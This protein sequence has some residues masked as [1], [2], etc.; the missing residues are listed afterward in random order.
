MSKLITGLFQEVF[1]RP[2]SPSDTDDKIMIQKNTYLLERLGLDMGDFWFMWDAFGPY[3]LELKNV[4]SDEMKDGEDRIV[5]SEFAK[6]Q[7]KS[8]Q[9][10]LKKGHEVKQDPRDWLEIICSL[11]FLKNYV[12]AG[13]DVVSEL[14]KRK[15]RFSDRTI[16]SC[17]LNI[18]NIIDS[19]GCYNDACYQA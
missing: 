4:I 13:G 16:T 12:I 1:E 9:D 7:I 6:A 10:I 19:M 8:V 11:H 17:A 5:F 18:V 2:Y 14:E 3:S 15:P